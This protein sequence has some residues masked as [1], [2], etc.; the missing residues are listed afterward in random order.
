MKL[1]ETYRIYKDGKWNRVNH[2]LDNNGNDVHEV[3]E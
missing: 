2:Y 3:I 1:L